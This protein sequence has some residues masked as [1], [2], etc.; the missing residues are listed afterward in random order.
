MPAYHYSR[1]DPAPRSRP[2]PE[3]RTSQPAA[4]APRTCPEPAAEKTPPPVPP[5]APA[6]SAGPRGERGLPGPMGP[7]GPKGEKGDPGPKGEPGAPGP[8]GEKGAPGPM[9]PAG[10]KGEKGDPGP[11][12]DPGTPGPRG[13]RG[14][15][16]PRGP[17][18]TG[19]GDTITIGRTYP[20]AAGTPPAVID[21]TG[22]PHHLLDFVLPAEKRQ[23]WAVLRVTG[24]AGGGGAPL[25]LGDL[26][27]GGTGIGLAP[28]RTAL[29]LDGGRLW[30]VSL[31]VTARSDGA[32]DSFADRFFAVTPAVNGEPVPALAARG[33]LSGEG[34][35]GT[36]FVSAAFLLPGEGETTLSLL[37]ELSAG[38]L[39]GVEGTVFLLAA[40]EL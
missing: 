36:A 23:S 13:E 24:Q 34:A 14:D 7:A 5:A 10:P 38:E 21:R 22:G 4:P 2:Q 8:R 29:E 25:L 12:G 30:L 31:L 17:A 28:D 39:S 35:G 33:L 27:Q 18:G 16:G 26:R 15:P 3:G 19:G 32:L 11:K 20:G 6:P 37:G 9:G 1:P 40:G